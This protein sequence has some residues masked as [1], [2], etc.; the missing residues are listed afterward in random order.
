M[1]DLLGQTGTLIG[2]DGTD[3]IVKMASNSDIKILDLEQ[4]GKMGDTLG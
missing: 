4:L 1:H 2:I 3:G